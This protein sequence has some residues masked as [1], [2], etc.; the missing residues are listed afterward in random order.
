LNV[1]REAFLEIFGGIAM[2]GNVLKVYRDKKTRGV[3]WN[4]QIFFTSWG[5][6]NL[7]YYPSLGQWASFAGAVSLVIS[8]AFY[9]TLMW[10][11]R[12]N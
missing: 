10:R 4:T 3:N 2:A 8:N 1:L 9:V 11:Y 6:W 12:K 7:A 5:I